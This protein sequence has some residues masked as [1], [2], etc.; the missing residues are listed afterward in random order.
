MANDLNQLGNC[1]VESLL[2]G[3]TMAF[4]VDNLADWDADG[5][6]S[7]GRQYPQ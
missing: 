1:R 6:A 4:L 7:S 5:H 2:G 3:D